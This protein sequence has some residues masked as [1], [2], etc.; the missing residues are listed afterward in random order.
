MP[1]PFDSG[2]ENLNS[3]RSL[4]TFSLEALVSRSAEVVWTVYL[5]QRTSGLY[6]RVQMSINHFQ[7]LPLYSD[8][9]IRDHVE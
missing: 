1:N 5:A 9:P 4:G 3:L 8:R 6:D 2:C 7:N